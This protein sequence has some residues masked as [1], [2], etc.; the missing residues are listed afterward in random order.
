[1]PV[2][3]RVTDDLNFLHNAPV[4]E[5]GGVPVDIDAIARAQHEAAMGPAEP[6]APTLVQIQPLAAAQQIPTAPVL[7]VQRNDAN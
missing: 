7:P 3:F 5:P 4:F 6:A 1:V 2:L